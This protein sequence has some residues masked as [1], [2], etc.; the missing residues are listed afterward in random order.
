MRGALSRRA[1]IPI[2]LASAGAPAL[3]QRLRDLPKADVSKPV[4]DLPDIVLGT[5]TAKVTVVE[6]VS[7]TC[8]HCA[9]FHATVLPRIKARYI[10]S[11]EVRVIIREFPVDSLAAAAAMLVRCAGPEKSADFVAALLERQAEWVVAANTQ[12]RL[13]AAAQSIAGF[14]QATFDA[15]LS[16]QALLMRILGARNHAERS[17]GVDGTPT[18]FI[19]GERFSGRTFEDFASAIDAALR[20]AR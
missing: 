18:F 8:P 20:G 5:A 9:R 19:E 4:A 14:T 17:F 11:G 13:F 3:A 10:D 16:D 7:L 1:L 2:L 12:L 15:C 6:Y